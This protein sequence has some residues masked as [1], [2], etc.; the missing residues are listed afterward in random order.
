MAEKKQRRVSRSVVCPNCGLHLRLEPKEIE[1]GKY[2][3]PDCQARSQVSELGGEVPGPAA[4]TARDQTNLS[5][6]QTE[7]RTTCLVCGAEL[8][9]GAKFCSGCGKPVDKVTSSGRL[10]CAFCGAKLDGD[11]SFCPRCGRCR[12]GLAGPPELPTAR[13]EQA[14]TDTGRI[15]LVVIAVIAL[16]AFISMLASQLDPEE[17]TYHVTGTVKSTGTVEIRPLP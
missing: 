8:G 15:F 2:T 10:F 17:T 3:C 14:H 1:S 6:V 4:E 7:E 9:E 12:R 5:S 16:I 13:S 11:E